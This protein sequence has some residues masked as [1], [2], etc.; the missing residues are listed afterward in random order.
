MEDVTSLITFVIRVAMLSPQV[1]SDVRWRR[2]STR[3]PSL[4]GENKVG[5][6]VK[7]AQRVSTVIIVGAAS[8]RGVDAGPHCA[9]RSVSETFSQYGNR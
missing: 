8:G 4:C 7:Q 2:C 3:I 9:R 6:Y 5:A 1:G